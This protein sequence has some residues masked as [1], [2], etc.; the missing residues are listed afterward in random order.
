M[1]QL[2]LDMR[3]DDSG[4]RVRRRRGAGAVIGA[5]L[6]M[7]L[8]GIA[9][10]VLATRT[11]GG[12]TDY[13]GDGSG[14]VTVVVRQGDS[15]GAIAATLESTGVVKT[16]GAFVDAAAAEPRSDGIAPG[17]Y[18]LRE[19]MSGTAA[20]TLMLDPRSRQASKVVLREGLRESQTLAAISK[21]AKLPMKELTEAA[22]DT[23]TLGVPAW[24]ADQPGG[25][26]GFLFPATYDLSSS[27]SAAEILKATVRRFDQA[28]E[29]TDIVTRSQENNISPYRSLVIASLV[30]AE[31]TPED[32]AK[33]SR[34]IFNRLAANMRLELDSTVNYALDKSEI[35]LSDS[36]L[37]VNSPYNTYRVKGL[38]PGPINSPGAEAIDAAL[39][40]A[41]GDWLYFVTV[42]PV[43]KITKFTASYQEFLKLK[44]QL[45][46]RL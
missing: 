44:A 7:L 14:S 40:P 1:S 12:S 28:A 18:V 29:D 39:S 20:V 24:G 2:G 22:D 25:V 45:R 3:E 30:Q 26:E 16:A 23:A 38:P 34:V 27:M 13:A 41:K 21:A 8:L 36:E 33:V 46:A 43:K 17:T 10:V 19:Q 11:L 4:E 42:D 37:K 35:Q 15:M 31:G 32:F 5:A 9:L 6:V